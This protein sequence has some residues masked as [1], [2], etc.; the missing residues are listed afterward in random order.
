MSLD[1]SEIR[2]IAE[3]GEFQKLIG[4]FEGRHLDAKSQP[5][6]F[7]GNDTKRE[8]AKDVAAFANADGGCIVLGAETTVSSLQAGEQISSFKPF[9][10]VLF[11]PDQH[12]KLIDEWSYP[13]PKGLII[14]WYPDAT[15]PTSGT[16]VIFIPTQAIEDKPFLITRTLGDKKTTDILLGY[17]ERRLDR[18]E[19]MSVEQLHHHLRTGRNLEATLLARI[20]NIETLLQRQL[21]ASGISQPPS[22]ASIASA[23]ITA[24]RVRRILSLPQFSD[25]PTFTVMITP[26]PRSELRSIFSNHQNSIRSALQNPPEFRPHG[27]GFNTGGTVEFIDGDFA[28]TESYRKAVT[29]YRDGEFIAAARIDRDFLAWADT[30]DNR[31]HPL[32][33]V[34]FVTN[35]LTFYRL[36]L[37][38]VRIA[39]QTLQIGCRFVRL[40]QN[41]KAI[42][43][44]TGPADNHG[45]MYGG[46]PAP[47]TEV[48][49]TISV[50]ASTFDPSRAAFLLLREI[51]AWF[52]HA[53]EAIPYTNGTG[54]DKAIDIATISTIK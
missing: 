1:L 23:T 12:H 32:A 37:A 4:E 22:L 5:Y 2:A 47:A 46:K 42:A 6:S 17:A 21:V 11:D 19:H 51:Y 27:W 24:S 34:E 48:S 53:E 20:T 8:L 39:P 54:D 45:W 10:G 16:G 41:D 28:H 25:V 9:P 15:T 26:A 29:L 38:D 35:S 33:F 7:T 14:N 18:T 50:D 30:T 40:H 49:R 13:V 3:T 36:V 44:P 52:G 43:L 31:L